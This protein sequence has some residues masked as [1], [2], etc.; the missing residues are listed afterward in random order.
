MAKAKTKTAT[1]IKTRED[2]EG[3]FGEYAEQVIEIDRLTV[4]ME[5]RIAEIRE[6]YEAPLAAAK[7]TGEAL[8]ADLQAWAVLHPEAFAE[9]KSIEL[10]HGAIGFRTCPPKVLQVP[11]V[12]VQHTLAAA[13]ATAGMSALIRHREDLDKDAVLARVA[14]ARRK[15]ADA[16]A[17]EEAALAA[18]GLRVTQDEVF[19]AEPKREN[20]GY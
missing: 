5:K 20:E 1:T 3:V 6:L 14:E 19:Y 16:L 2:L 10:L 17:A 18:V 13:R 4:E 12:K 11:G 8:V 7:E 15:G 9:R